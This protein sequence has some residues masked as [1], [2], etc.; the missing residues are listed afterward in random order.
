MNCAE[1]LEILTTCAEDGVP[2]EDR[3]HLYEAIAVV[4]ECAHL[5]LP[6]DSARK[7][8]ALLRVSDQARRDAE[9][10]QLQ[11]MDLL[12]SPDLPS[13]DGGAGS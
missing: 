13:P 7:L 2:D 12:K 8:A 11:F 10:M 4:A 3:A 6:A 1:A 5:T 9:A